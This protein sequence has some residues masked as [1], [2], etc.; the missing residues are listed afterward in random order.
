MFKIQYL[1]ERKKYARGDSTKNEN[2]EQKGIVY[3]FHYFYF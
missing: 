2:K 1:L 3:T